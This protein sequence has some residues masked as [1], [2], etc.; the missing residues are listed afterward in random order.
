M[1]A[2]ATVAG[3][4]SRGLMILAGS[5]PDLADLVDTIATFDSNVLSGLASAIFPLRQVGPEQIVEELEVALAPDAEVPLSDLVRLVPLVRLNAVLAVSRQ[6]VYLRDVEAWIDRLD[7]GASAQR[8][9]YVYYVQN[10]NAAD[11]APILEQAFPEATEPPAGEEAAAIATFMRD[12]APG[13]QAARVGADAGAAAAG[14][15]DT[16][17][18]ATAAPPRATLTSTP[19]L[20]L[21]PA[22]TRAGGALGGA[23]ASGVRII[24]DEVTNALVIVATEEDYQKVLAALRKLDVAPLQ[25]LVEAT[26]AEVTLTDE[27]R[28]GLQWFFDGGGERQGT[29][30]IGT[31]DVLA[32][33]FPGFSFVAGD[34]INV[35][36]DTLAG[37]TELN[38]ISSPL[39]MVLDRQT[40]ELNIGAEVPV[41]VQSQESST[42]TDAQ[43]VNTIEFRRTGVILN[44][45]PRVNDSGLIT[46]QVRQEVSGVADNAGTLTPTISQ[47]LIESSV[48]VESGETII[49]GG[50]FQDET[51][52][53]SS[54][55]PFL[56]DIPV[57][58]GLFGTKTNSVERTELIVLIRPRV[59]RNQAEARAATLEARQKLRGLRPFSE[60]AREIAPPPPAGNGDDGLPPLGPPPAP[61]E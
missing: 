36:L 50:L 2:D 26:I 58:G 46:M 4:P 60:A 40:A 9:I 31:D 44:V 57:F 20:P 38:V 35:V 55:I 51:Q 42:N 14:T 10:S 11:L 3:D 41:A 7:R 56:V 19:A 53:T 28:Y 34:P 30:T 43:L 39:L 29:L 1:P 17:G 61:V 18:A 5:R 32:S 59:V 16:G 12:L 22:A 33:T 47:R 23:A 52:E 45:T 8:N 48:V 15:A 49:L 25:V 24:A 54:G 27:L 37:I 21:P 6:E 13:A